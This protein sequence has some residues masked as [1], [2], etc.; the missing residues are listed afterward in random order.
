MKILQNYIHGLKFNAN[1]TQLIRFGKGS[2][3][4]TF[5]FC[6]TRLEYSQEVIHLGHTLLENLDDSLDISR[7]TKDLLRRANYILCTF[8][9]AEPF[10]HFAFH[11]MVASY[12]ICVINLYLIYKLFLTKY[13]DGFGIFLVIL[14]LRL[15][16]V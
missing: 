12:G 7:K 3:S 5:M 8:S 10:V 1:K 15:F 9:F 2:N 4:E 14:I 13:Y 11:C 6:G 16:T